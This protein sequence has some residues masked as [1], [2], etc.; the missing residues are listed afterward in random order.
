MTTKTKMSG[1]SVHTHVVDRNSKGTGGT[2]D[3][4]LAS[5]EP[6]YGYKSKYM[7]PRREEHA[8]DEYSSMTIGYRK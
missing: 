4:G 6:M 3:N 8:D 1:E 5:K 7:G 2:V